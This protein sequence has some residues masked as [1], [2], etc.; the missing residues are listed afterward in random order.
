MAMIGFIVQSPKLISW[1][2]SLPREFA[3]HREG[4]TTLSL[5]TFSIVAVSITLAKCDT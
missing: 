5:M 1:R 4:A 2:I 3:E